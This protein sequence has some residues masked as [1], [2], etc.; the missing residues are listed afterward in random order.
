MRRKVQLEQV[1]EMLQV[2]VNNDFY[3]EMQRLTLA[4]EFRQH[5]QTA[6]GWSP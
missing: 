6:W 2:V 4:G 1:Q 3:Y 5:E